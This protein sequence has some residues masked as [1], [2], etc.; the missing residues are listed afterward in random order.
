MTRDEQMA[1]VGE[2][3]ENVRRGILE[4]AKKWPE[5]WDGHQLRALIAEAFSDAN[6][7]QCSGHSRLCGESP[8]EYA[9]RKRRRREY[10]NDVL[11]AN[12]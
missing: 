6:C 9:A 8:A 4:N 5:H 11:T 10:E 3:I 7:G 1:F 2:L 12:L